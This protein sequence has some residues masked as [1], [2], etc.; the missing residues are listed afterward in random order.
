MK[1]TSVIWILRH[2][3]YITLSVVQQRCHSNKYVYRHVVGIHLLQYC[4]VADTGVYICLTQGY[5][6]SKYGVH[7]RE[8]AMACRRPFQLTTI[9]IRTN[10]FD[11]FT[12]TTIV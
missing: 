8:N 4:I 12:A 11:G 2:T 7:G 3:I 6:Y 10:S 5:K 1:Y 9:G